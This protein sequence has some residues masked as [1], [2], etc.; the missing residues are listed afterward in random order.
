MAPTEATI[1]STFLLPP[2][3][4]PSIISLK[5]FTELFPSAQQSSPQIR[6]LYR[7]LQRQRAR[8]TDAIAENIANEVKRGNA[9]RKAVVRTRRA[10]GW[11]EQDDEVDVETAVGVLSS[12][13]GYDRMADR[14]YDSCLAL[15]RICRFR[16]HIR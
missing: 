5:A 15:R 9:Q 3:P 16:N 14:E 2:A 12:G 8:L 1:L 13:R 10:E 4:L 6:T 7:D 11:A